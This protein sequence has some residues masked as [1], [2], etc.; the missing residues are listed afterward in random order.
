MDIL[1]EASE[2][3]GLSIDDLKKIEE[4]LAGRK[5]FPIKRVRSELHNFCC[6]IGMVQH[7]FKITP[8]EVIVDQ[9]ESFLAAEIISKNRGGKEMDVN[10]ATVLEHSATY[11][12]NDDHNKAVNIERR[13]EKAFPV[14]RLQSYRTGGMS[15]KSHFRSYFVSSPD[16][17]STDVSST[18]T[19]IYKVANKSFLS[20]TSKEA[21]E[22]YQRVLKESMHSLRPYIDITDPVRDEIRIMISIP[23]EGSYRFFSGISDVINHYGL[24]SK[25]KYAEPFA[26]GRI[27]YSF[28]LDAETTRPYLDNLITDISLIYVK[29]ENEL[30][31]LF[32]DGS[33]SAYEIFYAMAAW[34]FTHQFL[35]G[36]NYEYQLLADKLKDQPEMMGILSNLRSHLL[37]DAYTESRI[38]HT[39]FDYPE[40][41][42]QLYQHFAA[43]FSPNGS[44]KVE[45]DMAKQIKKEIPH[46]IDR[47]ILEG[48]LL[49]NTV[50]LKTNFYRKKK[51]SLAFRLEP[52]FLDQIEYPISPYGVFMVI[53]SE[54]RG[55]HIRFRDVSRGGIR[56]VRSRDEETYDQNSDFIFDE[57]YNL[58]A[59][60]Q[61]K[62][63][64]IPEGG[65]KGTILLDIK[66]Q[67][68]SDIA[69][70]KY[71]DGLLDLLLPN[72]RIK[73]YH[74]SEEILY[75]G[76]DEGTAELMNWAMGRARQ[77]G[78]KFWKAFS[79][80][81]SLDLGGIPHDVYGMTTNSVHEY[82]LGII[83]KLGLKEEQLTKVQ[84]GGPDGDLG[85][86]EILISKDKTICII[87]G[88][89]VLFEPD[90]ID[91]GELTRL[92]K[93][94]K[95]VEH[96]DKS[97]LTSSGF[98]VSV[99]EQNIVLPDGTKVLNGTTFRNQFHLNPLLKA[100]LFVPCGGRPKSINIQNWKRLLDESG[101]P[102][103][104]YVAEGANLFITQAARL[105]LEKKGVIIFKDASANKGGVT[106]SSLEVFV[107]LALTDEEFTE[108][109]CVKNEKEPEFRQKY[110]KQVLDIIR[111]NAK[112]EFEVIWNEHQA[113]KTSIVILTD[114]LSDRINS[115]TDSIQASNLWDNAAMCK[116]VITQHCPPVLVEKIGIDTIMKRVPE[117]YLKAIFAS[118]LASHFIY[119]YGLHADEIDF[120][121]FLREYSG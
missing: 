81:K 18:E 59:T 87:D 51:T 7:Y 24:V 20:T 85:S 98:F 96:F 82:V 107:S 16:Y 22:R 72:D 12:L 4:I 32:R 100:D 28:Y 23:Q 39:I 9:I 92:A 50:I 117:N 42:K 105:E 63:K 15:M 60:Q 2:A 68:K 45:K 65:S 62:N 37:K 78:Y 88:S 53:G 34:K 108:N 44:P 104:K 14:F 13:L 54:F 6:K 33:L 31:S 46:D 29:P 83:D 101:E 11:L 38:V 93:A 52:G 61:K 47:K 36:F 102:H 69:F 55:F 119:K 103:F 118:W 80:G 73:D 115:V 48:F 17:A 79:T 89:G 58:A 56:L 110:V 94:R 114:N 66:S 64:D 116:R 74:G 121:E 109:L 43:R 70:K 71:V 76:P 5:N 26:N 41:V 35:T 91:R 97:K 112:M 1:K 111:K 113:S 19:D 30:S 8:L 84:T 49:F 21:I 25:H 27:I 77:R 95:M 40:M 106:S 75:L 90:G 86:N 57:N 3:S 10:F 67:N 120:H 99:E